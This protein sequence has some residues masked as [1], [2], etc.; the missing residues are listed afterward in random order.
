MHEENKFSY[1]PLAGSKDAEW[2]FALGLD[3]VTKAGSYAVRL[4]HRDLQSLGIATN[5]CDKEHYTFAHL[6]V[7]ESAATGKQ[8]RVRTIGQTLFLTLCTTGEVKVLIRT[9][10]VTPQGAAWKEWTSATAGDLPTPQ[11]LDTIADSLDNK[12][13]YKGSGDVDVVSGGYFERTANDVMLN[14]KKWGDTTGTKRVRHSI[15]AATETQA[16][17]M[18]A[19][20]KVKLNNAEPVTRVQWTAAS[21]INTYTTTGIY[22]LTGERL[23]TADGLP[24]TNSNPGHT[25]HARLLVLDSSISGTGDSQDK[26]ITQVLTLSNRTGGD[27]DVYI[28]TGRASV[29]NQLA[30]GAG[31]EPWGKLQQNIEVGQVT[32]LDTFTGNGIYSGVYTNGNTFFETFVM[33]V[34]NNYLVAGATGQVRSI[35]Q[36]KYALNVDGTFSYKTRTGQGSSV[37]GWGSWVDLGAATTTDIQDGAITAQKLSSD[38][39][40]KVDNPLRPLFIAAGAEYNDTGVDITKTAPWGETVTHKAGYYYL[41][42]LGDITEEQMMKVYYAGRIIGT[43]PVAQYRNLSIRTNLVS[44]L[45]GAEGEAINFYYVCSG[46]SLEVFNN[47]HNKTTAATSIHAA[48]SFCSKLKYIIP[49]ISVV[50]TATSNDT[51]SAF[52]NCTMLVLCKIKGLKYSLSF[53]DSPRISKESILYTIQN[54]QPTAAITITLHADAYARLVDDTDIVAAL[55][56]QPLISLV[57]A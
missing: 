33:V 34:I 19:T 41:N 54:A 45:S 7:S 56:A 12:F 3:D 53:E 40:E 1:R 29:K 49:E 2:H 22:L 50:K 44:A 4:F 9:C 8:Q 17:V 13:V 10:E 25:I 36:F 52:T 51:V 48:F 46:S 30:A 42:G 39:R 23:N 6:F 21:N 57:S 18:S 26:C 15:S 35:S 43:T 32:S 55:E 5:E 11:E 47:T 14:L 28:R 38:V 31:W 27:G 24:I 20:D 16:G 37:I